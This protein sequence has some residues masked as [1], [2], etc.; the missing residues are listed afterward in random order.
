MPDYVNQNLPSFQSLAKGYTFDKFGG[1]V[2]IGED[3]FSDP[4]RQQ[5]YFNTGGS[6]VRADGF[7]EAQYKMLTD[8]A[9]KNAGMDYNQ[10]VTNWKNTNLLQEFGG[11]QQ[12]T[13]NGNT[14]VGA[15]TNN[16]PDSGYDTSRTG[17]GFTNPTPTATTPP[18]ATPAPTSTTTPTTGGTNW[19]NEANSAG[20]PIRDPATGTVYQPQ[21]GNTQGGTQTTPTS[22]PSGTT[23]ASGG[24]TDANGILTK[25]DGSKWKMGAAGWE[26]YTGATGGTTTPS[27][28]GTGG[29]PAGGV[30]NPQGGE[31]I[32]TENGQQV[33]YKA[34]GSR[35]VNVNGQWQ[36]SGG[37]TG[38]ASGTGGQAGT[39]TEPVGTAMLTFNSAQEMADYVIKNGVTNLQSQAWWST[40]PY[41]NEAW[42]LIQKANGST[43]VSPNTSID[44]TSTVTNETDFLNKLLLNQKTALDEENKSM[45]DMFSGLQDSLRLNQKQYL[46]NQKA[47]SDKYTSKLDA[48]QLEIDK[49]NTDFIAAKGDINGNAWLSEAG[50]VGKM[51]KL[52]S[53]YNDSMGLLQDKQKNLSSA[54]TDEMKNAETAYKDTITSLNDYANQAIKIEQMKIDAQDKSFGN[55]MEVVKE[56]NNQ[57]SQAQDNARQL[58]ATMYDSLGTAAFSLPGMSQVMANA[59]LSGV[60][61]AA[62]AQAVGSKDAADMIK[63]ANTPFERYMAAFST[64]DTATMNAVMAYQNLSKANNTNA[65][66]YG[67]STGPLNLAPLDQANATAS[68]ELK[69]NCVLFARSVITSL[70]GGNNVDPR[71]PEGLKTFKDKMT[72]ANSSI[73]T[74]GSAAI[75]GN[76]AQL[77]DPSYAGHVAVV[78]S[79]NTDTGMMTIRESN[80]SGDTIS[81]RIVP[82]SYAKGFWTD[83]KTQYKPDNSFPMIDQGF[84]NQYALYKKGVKTI[85]Q[86]YSYYTS[87]A[88]NA[89]EKQAITN[90]IDKK[91][92]SSETTWATLDTAT[93]NNF[94]KYFG[95]EVPSVKIPIPT[96]TETKYPVGSQHY[97]S[98]SDIAQLKSF[99]VWQ[100]SY[101]N[102]PVQNLPDDVLFVLLNS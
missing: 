27:A 34:D 28:T 18:A 16:V 54:M 6:P 90:Y 92:N 46:D 37:S 29:L 30:N 2:K 61:M 49:A 70:P 39:G 56:V 73:P 22:Q 21:T 23:S 25:A 64:G 55:T 5:A 10:Y 17:Q 12:R 84:D 87:Q 72:I 77:N 24:S 63:N 20:R 41:K 35:L 57:Q 36:P 65:G 7:N 11:T 81:E 67:L 51:A 53:A 26:P 13:D 89:T 43:T 79:S 68:P 94:L 58:L 8:W 38:G 15:A 31:R 97:L 88:K 33:W 93:A 60:D 101:S 32:V 19:Q 91:F 47:I 86:I 71:I 99:G 9:T 66:D 82:I 85:A 44:Y 75:I 1:T 48:V 3:F 59:G 98:T 4:T 45:A 102:T 95:I 50:R 69:S 78:V 74:P 42:A 52:Q 100:D 62:L 96:G 80:Y 40:S 83:P 76:M 14:A